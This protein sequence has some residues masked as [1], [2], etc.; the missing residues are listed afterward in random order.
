MNP[1]IQNLPGYDP[2]GE[3][4][5]AC[6][7]VVGMAGRFAGA[8]DIDAYWRNL[9]EGVESIVNLTDA[10][11]LAAGVNPR[12][13]RRP[14]YIKAAAPLPDMEMFDAGFFGMSPREAAIM[15]P[16]HRHFLECAW[17]AIEDA[18][19]PPERFAGA[20]GVF[21]GSGHNAY[22]PY[23][24]LTNPKLMEQVGFF[25]VRH[26]GNDKDFLTTRVSYLLNLRG[27]SVN[28][29]TAC[30][31]SL[32][33]IHMAVQS[34][35]NRECD[36]ALAGGATIE[37]PHRH[38]YLHQE[39]GIMSPDGHCRAFDA[40]SAGTVFGSGV[41]VVVLRRLADALA[42][43][44]HIYAVIK[45][46]AVNNDGAGKVGYLAPSVDGQA[47]A[48]TE[49][50][51]IAGTPASTI[52]YVEAHGTGTAVGDP[53]EVAALT[54]AYR[55][56]TEEVG[57]CGLGSVKGNIGHTD[58]AAGVASFIKVALALKHGELPPS[59]HFS[60]PN[61]ACE[62]DRS[63]FFVNA[64]LR[65]WA[66]PAGMP[67]RAGVSSLG[68]G[69]TNAHVILE[70]AP[71]RRPGTPTRPHQ[72]ITLSAASASALDA[73]TA[74]LAEHLGQGSA[75][76]LADI[77][78]TLTVGRQ[79]LRHRRVVAVSDA[80]DAAKALL[81]PA[82]TATFEATAETRHVY[83]MFAGGGAQ[84]PGMGLDLY[85]GEAVFRDAVDDCLDR[86][87]V[88][89]VTDVRRWLY[90][91][92]TDADAATAQ[93][94]RPSIGLPAL[95]AVQ[96]GLSKLWLHWGVTPKAMIGHSLGEYMAAHLAGVMALDDAL[97][98]VAL[99]GRL[100]ERLPEGGMLSISLSERELAP[101]L[102]PDLSIAAVN[103]PAMTVASGPNAALAAL[104][105]RLEAREIPCQIV[106]INIA[107]H[108]SML[109]PILA[110]WSAYL[111]RVPLSP[112]TKPFVSGLTG[113]WISPAEATD[114]GYWVNQM[115]HTVRFGDGISVL[116]KDP[117]CVLLEVGP[118]RALAS[119]AKAGL[120]REAP[121]A[122]ASM[123]H[124]D[125]AVSD[126]RHALDML[127]RLW[128]TGATVNWGVFW[129][130]ERRLRVHLPTYRF[131]RNRHWIEP[132]QGTAIAEE[133]DA[134]RREDVADW[135]HQPVWRR[136]DPLAAPPS[137]ATTLVFEGET[138]LGAALADL[139]VAGGADVIRVRPGRRMAWTG[140]N[141]V[142]IDPAAPAD[143][144]ALIARLAEEG[145]S[146][147]KIAHCWLLTGDK[148]FPG[149]ID[150]AELLQNRGFYSLLAL[151]QAL[152][153]EDT[154]GPV[155]VVVVTDHMLR[156]AGDAEIVPAKATV[157]GPCKVIPREIPDVTTRAIDVVLP[158]AG[159]WAWRELVAALAAEL[160]TPDSHDVVA[161]RA[162]E[163]W[164]QDWRP[165]ALKPAPGLRA[166]KPGGVYLITGGLGGIG[167]ALA[168][169]LARTVA[170]RLVLV[171]RT[172]L[173]P[174]DQ[175]AARLH[176]N[177]PDDPIPD[178][179]R[180]IMAI[181]RLGAEVL[182][183]NV[184]ATNAPRLRHAIR[185]ARDRFGTIDG[186]F[187]TAGVLDDGL[188]ALKDPFAASAVL[189]PK[190]RGTLALEEALFDAKPDFIMLFSSV[191]ATLGLA[192][193]ID[194]AAAN[195]FLDAYAQSKAQCDGPYVVAVDWSQWQDVGMAAALA[196][197]LGHDGNDAAAGKPTGNPLLGDVRRDTAT[198]RTFV[199]R[200]SPA[201]HWL[202]DEHRATAADGTTTPVLPGAGYMEMVRAA[203]A[204]H[205]ED[206]PIEIANV[207]FLAPFLVAD[208]ATREL[209]L[210]MTRRQG[211]EWRFT[212]EGRTVGAGDTEDW[213]EHVRGDV[214]YVD[215]LRPADVEIA[216]ILVGCR[217]SVRTGPAPTD[218]MRFGPRWQNLE[219]V[220]FGTD[221]AVITL[222]LPP[223]YA[224]ELDQLTL[225]P[226]LLDFATAG[227]QALATGSSSD[228]FV[229]ASYRRLVQ[230]APLVPRLVSHV[231]YRGGAAAGIAT[232][233]VTI[234][235]EAGHVLVDI[236]EF[237]M[238]R[239]SEKTAFAASA[240]PRAR[241]RG[242]ASPIIAHNQTSGIEPMQGMKA[243]ELILGARMAP[244]VAVSPQ[245][246]AALL[247]RLRTTAAPAAGGQRS[248]E[249]RGGAPESAAE[250]L[251]AQLWHEMLGVADIGLDDDFFDLG[252]HSLLAVQLVSKLK[253][254]TG[255]ALPLTALLEAPTLGGL[256]A[257]LGPIDGPADA[258]TAR[259]AAAAPRTSTPGLVRI[260][261]G[262]DK[263]PLFF[264]HDGLGETLLYRTLAMKLDAGHPVYGLQPRTAPDGSFLH[265]T[266][267]E[268]AAAHIE[269][270]RRAQPE[271]PY[272]LTGLCAG[273]VIAFE[274]ARQLQDAGQRTL[275]V[276][277]IDAADVEAAERPF[278]VTRQ[279]LQRLGA[280]VAGDNLSA[281]HIASL[282]PVIAR[283]I[284]NTVR[285]EIDKRRERTTRATAPSA[286]M[287]GES[288]TISFL[289]LYQGAHRLHRP[290]G[291]FSGGDVVLFKA[292]KGDGSIDDMPFGEQFS[293]VAMGWGKRVA[294]V[295]NV[296]DV[297]GG[298]SSALQ[299]PHVDTLARALQER[300]DAALRK[301]PADPGI[302][303]RPMADANPAVAVSEPELV[304]G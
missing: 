152:G 157:L 26:T 227:A 171:S 303:P 54:E 2:I 70:Q 281:G 223:R 75:S 64:A 142:T 189:A 43:D 110:E 87:V 47:Q 15:D 45:G 23:N 38:G 237:T 212:V 273:G 261:A 39:G 267:A 238:L 13:L 145:R 12:L 82:R 259:P 188:I 120:G 80:A 222:S 111:R 191:S 34:L 297:P 18:G 150:A 11:L 246:F 294:D 167:L 128:A 25:L 197:A 131:D 253:K 143:Y 48:I 50:L 30:S 77:A 299:P 29:Q 234:C 232:Y 283:R 205:G 46:S 19:H 140:K 201:T 103:G 277:I 119:L 73:N 206:R 263:L 249:A 204:R 42:D 199:A 275:F 213:T 225:H 3:H 286:A 271:G 88:H 127:G 17:A 258:G 108:S 51:A 118:G 251:V 302:T 148:P 295:V 61:P 181:E 207:V 254:R 272:L 282:A 85:E 250:R 244:Q 74:A 32:V 132:G 192:G 298:H 28:V 170:A 260:R 56:D 240:G 49:A 65:P 187:H 174:R 141:M 278:F 52:T 14:N 59:L 66:T 62:L 94:K 98:L 279:R 210:H 190:L 270:I 35:L 226:A 300:I 216:S 287:A 202:L 219:R 89:G 22:M 24:L 182:V 134:E 40:E 8:T 31:T 115:R 285:Y 9:R 114:P 113:T 21:A 116:V 276:G 1:M 255:R 180:R 175:W 243:I 274:I 27:P 44:D 76:D 262:G 242:A 55:K 183:V 257:L 186:V 69:G 200:L 235:D 95:F 247:A 196:R 293:D 104:R 284:G 5:E 239:V 236:T 268:M 105:S 97:G 165:V 229:P 91:T 129:Q 177:D 224:G 137:D 304:A 178:R 20:T 161:Y 72:L 33:A 265:T 168:D 133:D 96:Y 288:P 122:L 158:A 90:P 135:F 6:I 292:T 112:P 164:G 291:L 220:D 154:R 93:M 92:A 195:A 221:E 153:G 86:L 264:V 68:V 63:P 184:D 248:G 10:E 214:A 228:F 215:A 149:G 211:S 7:A 84:H 67:R 130:P 58:T 185:Q 233:D 101:L 208:G 198:E 41:G 136:I 123:R 71:G 100:F 194:Y 79:A 173:P 252:G 159:T 106:P 289:N 301:V 125:E 151:A 124:M 109:D 36:M 16:Q 146:P 241:P 81:D 209:R 172:P 163:R 169:H 155:D 231:R 37:L 60:A 4:D 138:G 230:Y 162:G 102:S 144:A 117:N 203:L 245:P 280:L 179:I 160:A 156:V 256:A 107:A 147:R 121:P 193:Q 57:Y 266:I 78:Y 269:S 83:F 176:A 139:L 218:R 99:R 290:S 53:I 217:S 126:V 166:L 296:I